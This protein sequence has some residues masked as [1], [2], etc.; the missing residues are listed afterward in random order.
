MR[1]LLSLCATCE[2]RTRAGLIVR[3]YFT[4]I[5]H[6]HKKS[7]K[8]KFD[9][10]PW[11]WC[12]KHGNWVW[13]SGNTAL[14]LQQNWGGQWDYVRRSETDRSEFNPAEYA[15]VGLR[16]QTT[17][18]RAPQSALDALLEAQELSNCQNPSSL[19]A[20]FSI[21]VGADMCLETFAKHFLEYQ[22]DPTHMFSLR[23]DILVL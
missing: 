4:N 13:S 15:L 8:G 3:I 18:L 1:W 21:L 17:K 20:E 9:R 16:Q 11:L 22:V 6:Q 12:S 10:F 19:P 2:E 23:P 5:S 7:A 14:H